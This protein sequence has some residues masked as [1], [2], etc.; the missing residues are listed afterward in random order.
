MK[1]NLFLI[2]CLFFTYSCDAHS[3]STNLEESNTK[4]TRTAIVDHLNK[5][6]QRNEKVKT[7]SSSPA[8]YFPCVKNNNEKLKKKTILSH[9]RKKPWIIKKNG[10]IRLLE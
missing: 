4:G 7:K 9:K 1:K 10:D 8:A 3:S 6:D 2:A 5:D